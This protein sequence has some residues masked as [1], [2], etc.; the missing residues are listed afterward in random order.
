MEAL[1]FIKP[2]EIYVRVVRTE[3]CGTIGSPSSACQLYLTVTQVVYFV[4][5]ATVANKQTKISC[6]IP[7]QCEIPRHFQFFFRC[8]HAV[9]LRPIMNLRQYVSNEPTV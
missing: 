7:N 8:K 5:I 2:P 6:L 1:I 3:Y 4:T 9:Y